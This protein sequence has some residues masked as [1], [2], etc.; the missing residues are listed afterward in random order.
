MTVYFN[1][2]RDRWMFNFQQAGKRHAGYC[3]DAEG[4]PV[5]SK[6]AAVQAE[7]VERRR[8][9]MQP[10]IA[11]PDEMTLAMAM[12]AM[13]PRWTRQQDWRNKKRYMAEL[14]A[15][16]GPETAIATID[17]ARI[18]AYAEWALNQPVKIWVG[19]PRK[20]SAA[21][22]IRKTLKDA[23]RTRGPG[24]VNLYLDVLRQTLTRAAEIRDPITGQS[25]LR[26]APKIEGLDVP[27]RRARPAPERVLEDVLSRVPEWTADAIH[28]TLYFGFRQGE[29]L[30][31]QIK[32]VD[33]DAGGVWLNADEVKDDEDAFLPGA[34]AAMAEL[35]RLVEQARSRGL[36]H[37]IAWRRKR[38]DPAAQAAEKWRPLKSPK[39]AWST[40]MKAIEKT[41][42]RRWRWHDIRAAFITHVAL[43]SG[44]VAAQKLARHSDYKTTDMYVDVADEVRR[45][46]ANRAADRPA[47]AL[48]AGKTRKHGSQT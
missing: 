10:K 12:A 45:S 38:K 18:E 34:P 1:K 36:K 21:P 42:G 17:A 9:A 44:P 32:D 26:E 7:G 47:L 27:K 29:A 31:L 33:F 25:A 37:L 24:T 39:R 13:T 20:P 15:F 11:R 8:A 16:F 43:T 23:T 14:L 28:L 35:A 19:G 2:E 46:A 3:L 6:S 5:K 22:S 41:Y 4:A 40:A 30:R 48:V